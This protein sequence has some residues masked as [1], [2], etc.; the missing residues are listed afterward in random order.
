MC[1][2]QHDVDSPSPSR[3]LHSS[4]LS[5]EMQINCKR[6]VKTYVPVGPRCAS[7]TWSARPEAVGEREGELVGD[8]RDDTRPGWGGRR[9]LTHQGGARGGRSESGENERRPNSKDHGTGTGLDTA[10]PA[11]ARSGVSGTSPLP[12]RSMRRSRVWSFWLW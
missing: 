7:E 10:M 11:P 1:E 9:R 5:N 8:D 6:P 2:S 12:S 4:L 3:D